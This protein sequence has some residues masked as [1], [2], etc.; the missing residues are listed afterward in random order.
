VTKANND[1]AKLYPLTAFEQ[2]SPPA[3]AAYKVQYAQTV[4][5][6]FNYDEYMKTLKSR[7]ELSAPNTGSLSGNSF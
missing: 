6:K 7:L 1:Q 5:T 2:T 4:G 3:P